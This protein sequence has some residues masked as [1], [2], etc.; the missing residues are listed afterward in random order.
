LDATIQHIKVFWFFSSEK[1][2]FLEKAKPGSFMSLHATVRSLHSQSAFRGDTAAM[3]NRLR[4]AS[5]LAIAVAQAAWVPAR[6]QTPP[7][8]GI[9]EVI[10]T[11]QKRTEK[12]QKVPMSIEVLDSKKLAQLQVNEFQDFIKYLPSVTTQTAG[13]NETTIYMRGVSSGDNANHIS[14]NSPPPPSAATSISTSTI[15]PGSRLCPA[16]RA[17]CSAPV[18]KPARCG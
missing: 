6:G 7:T 8:H 2:V 3:R 18:R 9:E 4:G 17:R 12:L 11:A 13:P 5:V 16:H 15:P 1:N 10:V 14:T